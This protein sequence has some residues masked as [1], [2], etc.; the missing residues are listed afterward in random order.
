[1]RARLASAVLLL[2][3]VHA[4]TGHGGSHGGVSAQCK[5][6]PCEGRTCGDGML[7]TPARCGRCGR[8]CTPLCSTVF[9]CA[10]GFACRQ[11]EDGEG[12][13]RQEK[14]C[15]P[16]VA[17]GGVCS[18]GCTRALPCAQRTCAQGLWCVG[19]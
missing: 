1:M 18:D 7:C 11:A 10:E 6:N 19:G 17:E 14:V 2:C 4:A 8:G 5:G 12:G 13:C 15:V 3:G 9:D 16:R